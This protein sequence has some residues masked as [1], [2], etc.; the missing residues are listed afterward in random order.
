MTYYVDGISGNTGADGRTPETAVA[1]WREL[2]MKPG[3]TVLFRR[4]SVFRDCLELP[5]GEPGRPLRCGAYGEGVR[6]VFM[7]SV[8]LA[9]P[10]LWRETA[11]DIWQ[12]GESL[13]TEPGN[14][15]FEGG[16]CGVMVW[17][18]SELRAQ[19]QWLYTASG[20]Q[21]GGPAPEGARLMLRSSGNPA[22]RHSVLEAAL[23]GHRHIA[24]GRSH[25][26]FEDL[27][28]VNAG[29]H[30]YGE[31]HARD[32]TFRRCEFRMIGGMVWSRE[33]RIRYGNALELWDDSRDVRVEE[34]LF[35]GVYDSCVTHQGP[36]ERAGLAVNVAFVGNTFRNYGMAAYEAR[37]KVGVDVRF[38]R[39]RCEGAGLGFALQGETP[40]RRSEIW[41][42]PMGHHL[43][44]WRMPDATE[45]G[46]I[47]VC[48]NYFGAAPYGA[49]IYSLA[50]PGA[51][52]QILRSGNEYAKASG[53]LVRWGGRD[54]SAE[55][56]RGRSAD[57]V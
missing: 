27:A 31:S 54:I 23:Y 14:L 28:F 9:Q 35:D 44:I 4:G 15:I 52:A 8:S 19:D 7:G 56:L 42:R 50:G 2:D 20:A 18:E 55:E 13:A 43:F 48:G 34:C 39:N 53:L 47:R 57:E 25:V 38:E 41:P 16:A 5:E 3:D 24:S 12:W 17:E 6:P 49:A 22:L 21:E 36:G 26:V 45:G 1:C 29:L 10:E 46:C 40:P 37:D 30:G 32:V 51:E 11:P 33:K